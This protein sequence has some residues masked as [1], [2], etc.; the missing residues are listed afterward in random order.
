MHNEVV[1]S[2]KGSGSIM[3]H[4]SKLQF[5]F[6]VTEVRPINLCSFW[7]RFPLKS[8]VGQQSKYCKHQPSCMVSVQCRGWKIQKN[9]SKSCCFWSLNHWVKGCHM[10]FFF[11]DLAV[12]VIFFIKSQVLIKGSLH[13]WCIPVLIVSS[14]E[15]QVNIRLCGEDSSCSA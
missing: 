15:Q 10:D 1:N 11:K 8:M 7:S 13:F 2:F 9:Y 12:V 4:Q 3:N 6:N 5:F 14:P